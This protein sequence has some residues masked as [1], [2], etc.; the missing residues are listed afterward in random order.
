MNMGWPTV[1]V[2]RNFFGV[3]WMVDL[4]CLPHLSCNVSCA[5]QAHKPL[6]EGSLPTNPGDL[7]V[8]FLWRWG[9]SHNKYVF[10][11]SRICELD[12]HN[13]FR[14]WIAR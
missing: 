10:G 9:L 3:G 1:C 7:W 5:C 13:Y 4:L 6:E 14:L 8:C 11:D 12:F 2:S